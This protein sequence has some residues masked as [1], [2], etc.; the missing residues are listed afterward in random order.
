MNF[1]K[2]KLLQGKGLNNFKKSKT[3][4]KNELFKEKSCF[5]EMGLKTY[6]K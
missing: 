5:A 6:K 1:L 3:P 4:S 2:K